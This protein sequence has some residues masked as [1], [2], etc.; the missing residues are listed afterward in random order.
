[1]AR[2]LV[3]ALIPTLDFRLALTLARFLVLSLSTLTLT[4]I[5]LYK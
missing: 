3:L 4:S 1:M 2:Q 5:L